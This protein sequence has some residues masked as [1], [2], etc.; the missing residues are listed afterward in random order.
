MVWLQNLAQNGA[1]VSTLNTAMQPDPEQSAS[2][3]KK[4]KTKQQGFK[5]WGY[6]KMPL[7]TARI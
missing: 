4:K 7:H 5:I 2:R 1:S 3:K 6:D